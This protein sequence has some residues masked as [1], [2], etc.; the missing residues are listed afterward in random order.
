MP[1]VPK[2]LVV[3]PH[4]LM[5]QLPVSQVDQTAGRGRVRSS[6]TLRTVRPLSSVTAE[7]RRSP[8]AETVSTRLVRAL[9]TIRMRSDENDRRRRFG[10]SVSYVPSPTS[11]RNGPPSVPDEAE[12]DES[13]TECQLEGE[14]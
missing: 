12:H 9:L 8:T 5:S 10:V 3:V 6:R 11:R 7:P 1:S 2:G 13:G 14:G 4:R